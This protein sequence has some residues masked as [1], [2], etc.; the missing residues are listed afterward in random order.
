VKHGADYADSGITD[1]FRRQHE[2]GQAFD[3]KD[4]LRTAGSEPF[5]EDSCKCGN[6]E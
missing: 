3:V 2:N 6:L 1:P 4:K 5:A